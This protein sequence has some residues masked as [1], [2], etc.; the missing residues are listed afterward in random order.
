MPVLDALIEA[1]ADGETPGAVIAGGTPLADAR[2][3]GQ[4]CAGRVPARRARC[5]HHPPG[6][7]HAQAAGPGRACVE[8]GEPPASD[9]IKSAFGGACRGG[10]LSTAQCLHRHGADS[11]RRGYD[12]RT[13]LAASAVP[14]KQ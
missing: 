5:P 10:H 8:A 1:G 13:P 7:R 11:D 6:R 2:A 4:W 9:E 12:D 3:F 14:H